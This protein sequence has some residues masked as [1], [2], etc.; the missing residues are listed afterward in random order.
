MAVHANAYKDSLK[1]KYISMHSFIF[2][3]LTTR[4]AISICY[5]AEMLSPVLLSAFTMV[6]LLLRFSISELVIPIERG[7][8]LEQRW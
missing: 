8:L 1:F 4:W 2:C 6:F 7:K 3:A 5:T